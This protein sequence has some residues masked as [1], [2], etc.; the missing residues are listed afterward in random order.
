[1]VPVDDFDA[2]VDAIERLVADPQ[3][4]RRMS[5]AARDRCVK[6]FSLESSA[7]RWC[8]LVDSLTP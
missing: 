7:R 6:E 1:V 5:V 3:L 2:L 4:R 8:E